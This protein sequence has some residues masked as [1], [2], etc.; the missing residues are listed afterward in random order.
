MGREKNHIAEFLRP[1]HGQDGKNEQSRQHD[2]RFR[3][4]DIDPH[5]AAVAHERQGGGQEDPDDAAKKKRGAAELRYRKVAQH[6]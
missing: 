6:F 4:R 1:T 3:A 2:E 5:S